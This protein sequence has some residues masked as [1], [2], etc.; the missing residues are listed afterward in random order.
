MIGYGDGDVLR[1]FTGEALW[2]SWSAHTL[3]HVARIWKSSKGKF[4]GAVKVENVALGSE[5][6]CRSLASF[7]FPISL[8]RRFF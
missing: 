3:D 1:P 6:C 4:A 5:N 7:C 8:C 2:R